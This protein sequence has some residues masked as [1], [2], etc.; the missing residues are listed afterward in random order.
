MQEPTVN[1]VISHY[2]IV[3]KLGAGGMGEVYLAEDTQLDRKIAL[4][5]LPIEF[6]SNQDRLRRFDQEAKAAAALNHP[7]IAHIY[8]VGEAD[9]THFIAM[10]FVD[11]KGEAI[12]MYLAQV[13][14]GFGDKDKAFEWLEKDYRVR[15]GVLPY[16]TWWVSFDD[17]RS[18]PRYA[19]LV[20]R[21]GLEP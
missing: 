16:I 5:L 20:R 12:G 11:V 17:L 9:G 13:Y 14:A 6:V 3:S 1:S 4:K 8:Q 10:E 19:D 2:R 18:D 21:M 7:N 15:S